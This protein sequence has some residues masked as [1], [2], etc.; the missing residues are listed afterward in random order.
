[1]ASVAV[2]SQVCKATDCEILKPSLSQTL[3][4]MTVKQQLL[5]AHILM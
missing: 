3:G 5:G 2:L 4:N 1:M